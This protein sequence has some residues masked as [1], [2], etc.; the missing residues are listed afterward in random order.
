MANTRRKC[1]CA[2][3]NESNK[4]GTSISPLKCTAWTLVLITGSYALLGEKG[5][6]Y[7]AALAAFVLHLVDAVR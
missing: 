2:D 6:M 3:R 5:A 4:N 7:S 1:D